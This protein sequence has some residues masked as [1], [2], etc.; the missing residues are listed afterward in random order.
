MKILKYFKEARLWLESHGNKW[1]SLEE[2]EVA[3]TFKFSSEQKQEKLR[4]SLMGPGR[5]DRTVGNISVYLWGYYNQVKYLRL[6]MSVWQ[7]VTYI[8]R[9]LTSTCQISMALNQIQSL[10]DLEVAVERLQALEAESKGV[11]RIRG[12]TA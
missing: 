12:V 1:G 4:W 8:I 9:H 2:F 5:H 7:F 10:D 11:N 3:F 6:E